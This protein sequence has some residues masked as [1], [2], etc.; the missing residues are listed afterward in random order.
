MHH[1]NNKVVMKVKELGPQH[2]EATTESPNFK[3]SRTW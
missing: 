2:E 1:Q 3:E